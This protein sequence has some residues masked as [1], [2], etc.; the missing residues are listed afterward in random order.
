M[1]LIRLLDDRRRSDNDRCSDLLSVT[2]RV[3]LAFAGARDSRMLHRIPQRWRIRGLAGSH[4]TRR[5]EATALLEEQSGPSLQV[6]STKDQTRI[7]R[8]PLVADFPAMTISRQQFGRR[9][10]LD[11]VPAWDPPW[12]DRLC[13]EPAQTKTWPGS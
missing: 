13:P 9:R 11:Q 1:P 4:L 12:S 8:G 3:G 10:V 5:A 7:V 2:Y 6:P